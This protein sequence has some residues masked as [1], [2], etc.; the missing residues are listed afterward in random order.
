[1]TIFLDGDIRICFPELD[2]VSNGVVIERPWQVASDE[3][4]YRLPIKRWVIMLQH[5]AKNGF[6]IG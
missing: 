1:M 6:H 5:T 4:D 2:C 3:V